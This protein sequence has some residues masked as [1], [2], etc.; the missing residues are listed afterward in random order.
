MVS[1]SRRTRILSR[2]PPTRRLIV[3]ASECGTGAVDQLPDSPG[4][5]QPTCRLRDTAAL[6]AV[7]LVVPPPLGRLCVRHDTHVN[8]SRP[9]ERMIL[10]RPHPAR[11]NVEH[12]FTA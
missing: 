1:P 12:E 5:L 6:H 2:K 3:L 10:P 7:E 4:F 8:S 9:A 11:T